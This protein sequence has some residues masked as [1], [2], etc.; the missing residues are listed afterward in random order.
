LCELIT[1]ILHAALPCYRPGGLPRKSPLGPCVSQRPDAS[2]ATPRPFDSGVG[3]VFCPASDES[4]W[5]PG[6]GEVGNLCSDQ[7]IP[8]PPPSESAGD[9]DSRFPVESGIG[10]SLFPNSR[11]IGNWGIPDLAGNRESGIPAESGI[12]DSLPDSRR[13]SPIPGQIGNGANGNWGFPGLL[14]SSVICQFCSRDNCY[15]LGL[16]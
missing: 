3:S 16:S 6:P 13:E 12:G 9:P 8:G 7:E 1:E 5:R 10:D 2:Q 15:N 14:V 4:P 11:R